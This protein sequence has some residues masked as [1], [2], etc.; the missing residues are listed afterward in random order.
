MT[1]LWQ[2]KDRRLCG[3]L[4]EVE[5]RDKRQ[6]QPIESRPLE[7]RRKVGLSSDTALSQLE[8]INRRDSRP[9]AKR[10]THAALDSVWE[11]LKGLSCGGCHRIT[12]CRRTGD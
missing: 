12:S 5:L 7:L 9:E 11:S 10:W 2:R 8:R 3:K 1:L 6:R 4:R